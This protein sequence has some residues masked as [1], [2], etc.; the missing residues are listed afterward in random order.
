MRKEVLKEISHGGC[1]FTQPDIR[2][3]KTMI[4]TTDSEWNPTLPNPFS[5]DGTY[6]KNWS[7][8]IYDDTISYFSNVYPDIMCDGEDV[9]ETLYE[10]ITR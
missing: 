5:E 8:F 10:V 2:K 7:A 9:F 4:Y 3:G 6:G 1:E